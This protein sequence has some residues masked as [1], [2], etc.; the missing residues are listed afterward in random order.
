ME[1]LAKTWITDG[2]LDPEYKRYIMLAYLQT[3]GLAFREN[4][5]YPKLAEVIAHHEQLL[6]FRQSHDA[7]QAVFPQQITGVNVQEQRLDTIPLLNDS[8]ELRQIREIVDTAIPAFE[9]V[10]HE[11][12]SIYDFVETHLHIE[13]VGISPLYK[14]EGYVLLHD[15][16]AKDVSIYRYKLSRVTRSDGKYST[17]QTD[18]IGRQRKT[19]EVTFEAIKHRLI[20]DH[21]ELPNPA[22]FRV[23]T[24]L[25]FP[26]IET[27]LPVSKR[28]LLQQLLQAA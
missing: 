14:L 11:G 3:V 24:D 4:K 26:L 27:Y 10:L 25:K 22:C 6:R 17:L 7:M 19:L 28:L 15:G 21:P 8:P 16:H 5:L 13:P 1:Q 12:K 18:F 23:Q 2:V 9:Q 20:A